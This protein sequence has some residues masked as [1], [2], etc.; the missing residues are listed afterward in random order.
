MPPLP[1][2]P[3]HC[4]SGSNLFL[5]SPTTSHCGLALHGS[6]DLVVYMAA[7]PLS[8]ALLVIGDRDDDDVTTQHLVQ[9][10]SAR[11]GVGAQ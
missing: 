10:Y 8:Y 1:R 3:E 6:P 4:P 7:F 11:H 9:R 2:T 5:C